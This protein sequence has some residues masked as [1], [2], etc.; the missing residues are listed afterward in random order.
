MNPLV[1]S[2]LM[3]FVRWALQGV[4]V[5]M[6]S[7]GIIQADQ[8]EQVV[9]GVVG[10]LGTLGWVLWRKYRDRLKIVTALSAPAGISERQLE[11]QIAAGVTPPVTAS[12][13]VAP[14]VLPM[15]P[16]DAA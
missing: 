3:G 8:Q 12:K 6:V 15:P 7:R 13:E 2:M 16:K 5:W 14:K 1:T 10:A 11:K 9:I 4:F